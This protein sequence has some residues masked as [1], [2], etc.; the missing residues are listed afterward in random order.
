M[1]QL[2]LSLLDLDDLTG[3]VSLDDRGMQDLPWA[4]WSELPLLPQE[5]QELGF[6][7]RRLR[8][9]SATL[10]NEATIWSRVVFPILVLA[11]RDGLQAWA[12]VPMHARVGDTDLDGVVDGALGRPVGGRLEAPYLLVVEAKRGV[13]ATAPQYQLY[14]ELLAAARV[15]HLRHPRDLTVVHGCMTVADTFTFVRAELRDLDGPKPSMRVASSRELSAK[16]EA[17]QILAILK[18]VV[19]EGIA[20]HAAP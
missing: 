7:T 19:A 14:G 6:I 18:S 12:Q 3:L 4:S 1:K 13:D 2:S 9:L 5:A 20:H 11:E 8:H 10:V 16:T 15:H 17:T